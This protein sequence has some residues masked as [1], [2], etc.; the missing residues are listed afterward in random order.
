MRIAVIIPAYN[1]EKNLLTI[2]NEIRNN[3]PQADV[4]VV[5]DGSSDGTSKVAKKAHV[6]LIS[7]PFNLRIGGAVQTGIKYAV[8][9]N[10]EIVVQ[11]DADGQHDPKYLSKLIEPIVREGT[12]IVIGSRFLGKNATGTS[13]IRGLGIRFFSW[14]VKLIT[15]EKIVDCSSGFR[16]LSRRAAVFFSKYYPT[17]FPDA[18]ALIMAH[19]AGLKITE[20][21][22][23][24]RNRKTGKSSLNFFRFL[25]YPI[26][27]TLAI[28]FLVMKRRRLKW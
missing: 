28:L 24:F 12:D 17:D 10:Y 22:T 11:V 1:E 15:G 7:L 5:D 21:R 9:N 26:K 27:E 18:E 13:Y 14:L 20:V 3:M 2:I 8:R 16:A 25:Y 19:F 4:I 6:K 23:E